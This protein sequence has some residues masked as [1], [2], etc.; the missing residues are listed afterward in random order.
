MCP[1]PSIQSHAND[2][3]G[4]M[5]VAPDI[6]DEFES[7]RFSDDP[8]FRVSHHRDLHMSLG[9]RHTVLEQWLMTSGRS[10]YRHRCYPGPGT[11]R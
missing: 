1:G 7:Y 3:T 10:S 8:E 5:T 2:T 6:F 11:I 9:S 4:N